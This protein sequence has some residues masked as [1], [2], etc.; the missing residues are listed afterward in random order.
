M[1]ENTNNFLV[2]T[3]SLGDKVKRH[4]LQ[5][6]LSQEKFSEQLGFSESFYSRIER[7]ERVVSLDSLIKISNNLNLSLD[8]LLAESL[9][10]NISETM[11]SKEVSAMLQGLNPQQTQ[12]ILDLLR[13]VTANI[14]TLVYKSK[15]SKNK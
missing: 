9:N 4:R 5:T 15:G 3:K 10:H 1:D 11:P 12:Y 2:N 14:D 7:G 6:G 8:Y 13:V